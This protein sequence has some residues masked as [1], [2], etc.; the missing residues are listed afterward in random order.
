MG[1]GGWV[2]VTPAWNACG[3]IESAQNRRN[4]GAKQ[5]WGWLRGKEEAGVSYR[6]GGQQAISWV[7]VFIDEPLFCL[8][9]AA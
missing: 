7:N 2:A 8:C 9:L 5:C 1:G 4:L 6:P 3:R